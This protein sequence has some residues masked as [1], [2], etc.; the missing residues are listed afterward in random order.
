M[1]TKLSIFCGVLLMA[2][3]AASAQA[4]PPIPAPAPIP[5][6]APIPVQGYQVM[7]APPVPAATPMGV[8][9]PMGG[10]QSPTPMPAPAAPS[11]PMGPDPIARNL[12]PPDFIMSHAD[13][14]GLTPDQ[15]RAIK[16]EVR[17]AQKQFTEMQWQLE[18]AVE[19][20]GNLLK[21]NA[22]DEKAALAQLEKVLDLERSIKRAQMGLMIRLKNRLNANQQYQLTYFERYPA[23]TRPPTKQPPPQKEPTIE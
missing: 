12:F 3:G 5:A 22:V 2:A 20:M 15:T 6:A 8:Q 9:Q 11:A 21:P 13:D 4:F 16:E 10:P 17:D 14:I 19:A 18:D 7:P 1:K 23:A